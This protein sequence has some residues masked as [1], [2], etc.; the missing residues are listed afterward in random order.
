MTKN[1]VRMLIRMEN[2]EHKALSATF[3]TNT[4]VDLKTITGLSY[5]IGESK[6]NEF[7]NIEL[8]KVEQE[9]KDITKHF[10]LE[11]D[12][13]KF[14]INFDKEIARKTVENGGIYLNVTVRKKVNSWT[15]LKLLKK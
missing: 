6:E 11:E 4:D 1:R 14:T 15:Q 10:T 8:V 9:G 13:S 12:G 7:K 2:E 5:K 3:E